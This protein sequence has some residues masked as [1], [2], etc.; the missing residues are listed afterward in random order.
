MTAPITPAASQ[1]SFLSNAIT[2]VRAFGGHLVSKGVE[3]LKQNK[4]AAIVAGI[5]TVALVAYKAGA[6]NRALSALSFSKEKT[7]GS[8]K[9]EDA[10]KKY[11]ENVNGADSETES[12]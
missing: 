4:T 8:V 1:S 5:A 7:G 2:A 6:F 12:E 3:F 9:A 10:A 11:L